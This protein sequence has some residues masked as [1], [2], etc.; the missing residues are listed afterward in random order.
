MHLFDRRRPSRL[1]WAGPVVL[2]VYL[3]WQYHQAF[4]WVAGAFVWLALVALL[5]TAIVLVRRRSLTSITV[6][7]I[8]VLA[9]SVVSD[10]GNSSGGGLRDLRLYLSAGSHFLAGGT[11]YTVEPIHRYPH[12][13]ATLPFLYPPPTLPLFAFLA[14]LPFPVA[15]AL[16]VGGGIAAVVCSLRLLGLSWRWAIIGLLWPPIEQGIFVGNV[17]APSLLLLALAPRLAGGLVVGGILKP[18]H[19]V[20]ALWLLRER[21]WRSLRLG[22]GAVVVTV[23]VT[24]PFTGVA[25]WGDW[26]R[27][28]FAYRV[29]QRI[30]GGLYGVGLG[31]Y[32]PFWIFVVVVAMVIILAVLPRGRE[33]LSRLGLASAVA[34]PS[35]WSHGFLVAIP[36]FLRLRSSFCWLALGLLCAG[37]FPGPQLALALP[38]AG[39]LGGLLGVHEAAVR[40]EPHPLGRNAEP[41]P[42]PPNARQVAAR[43]IGS[44]VTRER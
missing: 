33:S 39:W 34:S 25:L 24:L 32:V 15:A 41:W 20:M 3:L 2:G 18:Q 10:V 27:G 7:A 43:P 36:A 12:D 1:G 37:E 22:I 23:L 28:L 11:V 13:L 19:G 8:E 16:W 38:V 26:V 42:D 30:L 29:S 35:L 31:R 21:A 5:A 14:A 9:A 6:M 4:G 17:A 40:G 44:R